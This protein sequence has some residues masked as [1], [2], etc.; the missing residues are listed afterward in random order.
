MYFILFRGVFNN[1][2]SKMGNLIIKVN[3]NKVY[4][5]CSAGEIYE[6]RVEYLLPDYENDTDNRS[7]GFV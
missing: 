2:I 5:K 6:Q 3:Y 4:Y 7:C 1:F